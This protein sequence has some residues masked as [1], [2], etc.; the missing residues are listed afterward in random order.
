MC[1]GALRWYILVQ[2]RFALIATLQDKLRPMGE[3]Y[4]IQQ[5][6]APL[7]RQSVRKKPSYGVLRTKA[8]ASEDVP[9]HISRC[10][11]RPKA[12]E[13]LGERCVDPRCAF[14]PPPDN[15]GS[16]GEVPVAEPMDSEVNL[17]DKIDDTMEK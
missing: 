5:H 15:G 6:N 8:S 16:E 2:T 14:N 4:V 1:S 10:G 7:Q 13:G 3:V 9:T 12:H 17:D 11:D